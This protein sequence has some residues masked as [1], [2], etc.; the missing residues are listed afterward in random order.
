MNLNSPAERHQFFALC[1]DVCDGMVSDTDFAKLES[2]LSASD[3]ARRLY[4]G[5]RH[6]H[7][8]VVECVNAP[9]VER[10]SLIHI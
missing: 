5:Y 1:G 7:L 3:E 9:S 10:L 8:A 4:V 2:Q 6:V